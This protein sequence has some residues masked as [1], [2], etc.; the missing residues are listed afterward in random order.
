MGC[1]KGGGVRLN[2]FGKMGEAHAATA[3]PGWAAYDNPC[4]NSQPPTLGI[5]F[6]GWKKP[7][8]IC[9]E[10]VQGGGDA[11]SCHSWMVSVVQMLP[12]QQVDAGPC[13]IP[14]ALGHSGCNRPLL[15]HP[16]PHHVEAHHTSARSNAHEVVWNQRSD[17]H[18][19]RLHH[20][21]AQEQV[22]DEELQQ[23]SLQDVEVIRQMQ[24]LLQP[25]IY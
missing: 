9:G 16:A 6:M 25:A 8:T 23:G 7:H 3:A 22:E 21:Q 11:F 19:E 2:E 18:H 15:L 10:V 12:S 1:S 17:C 14:A 24:P 20:R 5:E 4:T 13:P